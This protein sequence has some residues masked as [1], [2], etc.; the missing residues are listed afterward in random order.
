MKKKEYIISDNIYT[1]I[2]FT[3]FGGTAAAIGILYLAI[4]IY[5]TYFL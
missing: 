4:K 1:A 2:F 5:K 3:T